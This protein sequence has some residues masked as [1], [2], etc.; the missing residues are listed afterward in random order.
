MI[1]DVVTRV[2]VLQK[3]SSKSSCNFL[4]TDIDFACH[5]VALRVIREDFNCSK[6]VKAVN[7][8][9]IV[10]HQPMYFV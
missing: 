4:R 10:T 2:S 1:G 5:E 3:N 7:S 9:K 6:W 8:V